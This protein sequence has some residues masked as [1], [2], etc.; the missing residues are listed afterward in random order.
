MLNLLENIKLS[1][2]I[3]SSNFADRVI[4]TETGHLVELGTK[5]KRRN[6]NIQYNRSI[7]EDLKNIKTC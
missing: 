2:K 1:V 4:F 7:Y 6:D 5:L 3:F